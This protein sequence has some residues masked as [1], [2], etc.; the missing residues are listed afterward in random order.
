MVTYLEF[1]L[2]MILLLMNL[3]L[4]TE[5]IWES[6]IP[7]AIKQAEKSFPSIHSK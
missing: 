6:Y 5:Q 2:S 7:L 4:R 1:Y 3:C